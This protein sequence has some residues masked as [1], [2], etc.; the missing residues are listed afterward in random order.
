MTGKSHYIAV[1]ENVPQ[2]VN[3]Q[4]A[5]TCAWIFTAITTSKQTSSWSASMLEV[6][7]EGAHA[8]SMQ[9]RC[10][11]SSQS[12]ASRGSAQNRDTAASHSENGLKIAPQ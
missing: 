12:G 9:R 11:G 4:S 7:L 2:I 6:M 1:A 5:R 8:T 10:V 3:G